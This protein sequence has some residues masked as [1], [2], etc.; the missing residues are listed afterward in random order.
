MKESC[1]QLK[2]KIRR[3]FPREWRH[4]IFKINFSEVIEIILEDLDDDKVYRILNLLNGKDVSKLKNVFKRFYRKIPSELFND[5]IKE[6]FKRE[7]F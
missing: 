4:Q 7:G 3:K 2:K 5:A 1:K 6:R